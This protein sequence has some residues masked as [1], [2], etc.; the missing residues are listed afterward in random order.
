M[1]AGS[2]QIEA[3]ALLEP[4]TLTI[5]VLMGGAS[6]ER[7]VSLESGR[8]VAEALE[9]L[10]HDVRPA[11]VRPGDVTAGLVRDLD[12]VFLALHGQWGEDGGV[13]GELDALGVCYTGSGPEASR[14]AM[15]KVAAKTRFSDEGVPTPA[16]RLI[17]R[18]DEAMLA[19]AMESIGPDLVVKP[20][21]E[22]SSIDVYMVASLGA[23]GSAVEEVWARDEPALIERRIAGREF[24]VGILGTSPL[25]TIEIRTPGGWYDYAFKYESDKTEY[26][27]DHGLAPDVEDR[28]VE[29]ALSAHLVLGCRDFSR[30]DMIVTPE[31]EPEVLEVNT[32]PGFTSHSLVPKAAA[33]AGLAFERLCERIVVMARERSGRSVETDE[34]GEIRR[35]KSRISD[36]RLEVADEET[37]IGKGRQEE[38]G[39]REG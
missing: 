12:V 27:F 34:V 23:L 10:G 32:I 22:G 16:F 37:V 7:P 18:G 11:D 2:P 15:D 8:A 14:L 9:S 33:R 17:E 13:Q 31:G 39:Q 36:L 26:I 19:E 5:G 28:L 29:A 24:T 25:P 4:G 1:T 30:V 35:L 3:Q 38:N 20:V 21:A 6:R